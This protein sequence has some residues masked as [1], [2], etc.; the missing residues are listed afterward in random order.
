MRF[1]NPRNL[2]TKAKSC[3]LNIRIRKALETVRVTFED[4]EQ[5]SSHLLHLP[6]KQSAQNLALVLKENFL[7]LRLKDLRPLKVKSDRKE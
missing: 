3:L 4:F 1:S 5:G 2:R 6:H 7:I